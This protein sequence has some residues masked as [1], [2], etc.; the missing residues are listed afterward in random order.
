MMSLEFYGVLTMLKPLIPKSMLQAKEDMDRYTRELVDRRWA[1]GYK[2]DK[3]D[4]MNYLIQQKDEEGE[5]SRSAL[6][7]NGITLVVAGSET[8]STLLTG[9]T[10]LLCKHPEVMKKVQEE[11]R[12]AFET[13]NEITVKSVN[14]LR[15]MLAVLN[16]SM[17]VFP[18]TAFGIPRII[19]TK[20]GQEVAGNYLP[21][22]VSVNVFSTAEPLD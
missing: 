9:C 3:A 12:S 8:T 11:V 13:D 6:Y 21:E 10:W 4:V 22:N 5:L 19:S 7:E 16:E 1:E 17:R 14:S 20:G 15:Y 18:P 2:N